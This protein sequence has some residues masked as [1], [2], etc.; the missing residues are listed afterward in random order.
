MRKTTNYGLVLYDL[1]DKM[2]ITAEENSLNANMEIIDNVLKEI[3]ENAVQEVIETLG[4][5]VFGRIDDENNII[6]TGELTEGTYVFAYEDNNGNLTTIGSHTVNANGQSYYAVIG[7]MTYGTNK[8]VYI[9]T[10]GTTAPTYACICGNGTHTGIYADSSLTTRADN[11]KPL[12]V[13]EGATKVKVNFPN[14]PDDAQTMRISITPMTYDA[15]N[16]QWIRGSVQSFTDYG[17]TECTFP[18]GVEYMMIKCNAESYPN[19]TQ[20]DLTV[21]IIWE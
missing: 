6:L 18:A 7:L 11:I 13:P 14:L 15:D 10:V 19:L 5:P 4:T 2:S 9:D 1:E 3:K 20:Y 12:I 17:V 16:D 8:E 21:E